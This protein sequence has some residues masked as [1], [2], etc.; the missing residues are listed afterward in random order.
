[1]NHL[2]LYDVLAVVARVMRCDADAAIRSTDVDVVD[3]VLRE[4]VDADDVVGSAAVLLAGLVRGRPFSGW[5]R[6]ISVVVALQLVAVNDCAVELEPVEELDVLL[7]RMEGGASPALLADWLR[8]RVTDGLAWE[9]SVMFEKFS[10]RGKRV[11]VLAQEQA[12]KLG[13]Q[14]IGT[15]HLLI[16]LIEEDDGIAAQVLASNGVEAPAV[17]AFVEET[18]GLGGESPSGTVPFTPRAKKVL[19]LSHKEARKLGSE[20]IGPGHLLLGLV[21]EGEGLAAQAIVKA[22]ADLAKVRRDVLEILDRRKRSEAVVQG[23]LT[24]GAEHSGNAAWVAHGRR[25]HLVVELTRILDENE[26]LHEEVARL[27]ELLQ[28]NDLDPDA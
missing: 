5:N 21:R 19:E 16:G 23:F 9:E 26:R 27:R 7:D 12:R 25:R 1:M 8:L 10:D 17:R 24:E 15:E 20:Q 13:H 28:Q 14:Y 2:G 4:A 11:V 3:E 6:R 18:V 22:G